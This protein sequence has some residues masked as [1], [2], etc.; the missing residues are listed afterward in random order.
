MVSHII[1]EV[2]SGSHAYGFA[3][4]DSD[5]DY[6]GI[7]IPPEKTVL[8]FAYPFDQFESKDPDRTIYNIQK[9]CKLASDANPNV[10]ELLWIPEKLIIKNSTWGELLRENRDIFLSKKIKFTF[11]GY[12]IAQLKRIQTH[13]RWLLNPPKVQ[14]AR[15]EYGL[16]ETSTTGAAIKSVLQAAESKGIEI[17]FLFSPEMA[18]LARK[19]RAFFNAQ[20]EWENYE[21]WKKNRNPARAEIEAKYGYDCKHAVHLLRL[22]R[23]CKEILSTGEVLVERPDA[24]ELRA[25]RTGSWSYEKLIEWAEQQDQ[26]MNELYEKSL[27]P[28]TADIEKINDLCVNLIKD[29]QIQRRRSGST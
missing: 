8:G 7:A 13:K 26:E 9:F 29:F 12:A 17:D 20:K 19:E 14:P 6:R 21:S 28:R 16:P 27:L 25:I 15:K 5:Y 4:P 3:T 22:L 24:E 18:D 2:I 23:M 10:I 11:S 1:Y